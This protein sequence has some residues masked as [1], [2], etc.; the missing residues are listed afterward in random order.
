MRPLTLLLEKL[1]RSLDPQH[2]TAVFLSDWLWLGFGL[3]GGCGF[4]FL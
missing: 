2:F 3:V 4:V 1:E